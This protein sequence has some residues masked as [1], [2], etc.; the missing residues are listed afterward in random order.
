MGYFCLFF[1]AIEAMKNA[2]RTEMEKELDKARKA[3]SNSG[4]ADVEEIRKQH[5]YIHLSDEILCPSS[6]FVQQ[7]SI[8]IGQAVCLQFNLK[9]SLLLTQSFTGTQLCNVN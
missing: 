7:N 2:H 9:L 6:L 3:N 8:I 4:N 5:E 1:K